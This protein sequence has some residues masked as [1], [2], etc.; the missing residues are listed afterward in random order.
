MSKEKKQ[1]AVIEAKKNVFHYDELKQG[2]PKVSNY[3][4]INP[5]YNPGCLKRMKSA[6]NKFKKYTVQKEL[7]YM[8]DG[9]K[10]TMAAGDL[11]SFTSELQSQSQYLS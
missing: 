2:D 5:S 1:E 11:I 10:I 6:Y 7:F 3:S 4:W 9:K 8:R